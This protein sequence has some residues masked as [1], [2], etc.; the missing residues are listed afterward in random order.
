MKAV[1]REG[2]YDGKLGK[3][4][5]LKDP[6]YTMGYGFGVCALETEENEHNPYW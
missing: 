2:Y 5:R 6:T 1:W 3:P 4:Q